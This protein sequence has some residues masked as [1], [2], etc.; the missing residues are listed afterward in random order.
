MF[1]I[2][3]TGGTGSGKTTIINRIIKETYDL[4]INFISSDTYYK[5]NSNLS[6]SER[7]KLNYDEPNAMDF[8]LL[9]SQIKDLKKGKSINIPVYCFNTH[10]RLKKTVK[11]HPSKIL[12]IEGILIL[13]DKK[14]REIIDYNI[15]LDCPKEIRI[16]RRIS[17]DT[18]ERGRKKNDIIDLFHNLLNEMHKKWVEPIKKHCD[19]ILDTSEKSN[20]NQILNIIIKNSH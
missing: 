16:R 1:V 10:L 3:I 4:D 20:I 12:V 7:D 17:R 19:L 6:F 18:E 14:L 13:N 11:C 15:F 5:D 2:G 9:T 8:D